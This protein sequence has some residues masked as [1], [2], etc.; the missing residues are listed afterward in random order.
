MRSP[1][2][3]LL[4]VSGG[5]SSARSRRREPALPCC[6]LLREDHRAGQEGERRAGGA[7]ESEASAPEVPPCRT[8]RNSIW[9]PSSGASWKVSERPGLGAQREP[10]PLFAMPVVIGK[11]AGTRRWE[12]LVPSAFTPRRPGEGA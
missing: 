2:P 12:F 9:I 4:A 10:L 1:L 8:A 5:G 7:Q 3:F 11:A 6:C